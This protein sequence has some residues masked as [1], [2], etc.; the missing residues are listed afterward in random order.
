MPARDEQLDILEILRRHDVEFIVVGGVAAVL[1]GAPV[2]TFDTDIVHSRAEANVERLL[3]ALAELE[4]Y[5]REHPDWKP[6]PEAKWLMGRGHHLLATT[7]GP[8]DVLCMLTA[9]RDYEALVQHS[10]WIE[11]AEGVEVRAL[12]LEMLIRL[13]EELHRDKDRAVLP[14]LRATLREREDQQR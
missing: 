10:E 11:I 7:L 9:E 8:L 2:V 13:K 4:A 5:Y 14:V 3:G 12:S 6:T 1:Q